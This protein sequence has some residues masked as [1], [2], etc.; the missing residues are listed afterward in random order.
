MRK[1]KW[2]PT[3]IHAHSESH[4]TQ[5]QA[6]IQVER[7][8]YYSDRFLIRL[9]VPAFSVFRVW[10]SDMM[11]WAVRFFCC[12]PPSLYSLLLLQFIRLT[13]SDDS[14]GTTRLDTNIL[15]PPIALL[16]QRSTA[17]QYRALEFVW[18]ISRQ[19]ERKKG[20]KKKVKDTTWYE[21]AE[22]ANCIW[23]LLTA[24]ASRNNAKWR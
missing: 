20:T 22:L 16:K 7:T 3:T 15:L 21:S 8:E 4:P 1:A 18:M 9:K 10:L 17:V 6:R 12:Q 11:N 19:K 5:I 24:A 2:Q 13:F 14:R 23:P